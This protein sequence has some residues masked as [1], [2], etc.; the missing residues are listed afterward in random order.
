MYNRSRFMSIRG[1]C[2]VDQGYLALHTPNELFSEGVR[3]TFDG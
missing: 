2:N 3:A 1:V